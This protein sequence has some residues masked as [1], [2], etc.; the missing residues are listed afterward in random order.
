M[1]FSRRVRA[2]MARA[3][4]W[5]AV[6][7]FVTVLLLIPRAAVL[8]SSPE[9]DQQHLGLPT[10]PLDAF[11]GE[12][13]YEFD[14]VSNK[15]T[16]TY[17]GPLGNRDFVHRVFLAGPTV[18]TITVTYQ[19]AGRI[20][21]HIPDTVRVMLESDEYIDPNSANTFVFG[22]QA[23]ISIATSARAFQHSLSVS[24]RIELESGPPPRAEMEE[25]L[26]PHRQIVHLPQLELAHVRQRATSWFSSCE[27]LSMIAE[28]E[29]HG[30]L[31]GV[32]FNLNHEVVNGL[33]TLAA[34]MLPDNAGQRSIDCR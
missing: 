20:A 34:E 3:F 28:R 4:A 2:Q 10:A 12:I 17:V 13:T 19:F 1:L 30:S 6:C 26:N 9:D 22:P 18:H 24:R 8:A 32:S 21:A 25:S 31:A 33:K 7:G 11:A 29:I 23:V 5:L 16:A 15:T 27:F 14:S